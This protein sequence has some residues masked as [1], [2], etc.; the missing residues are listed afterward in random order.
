MTSFPPI[1]F[2]HFGKDHPLHFS[3]RLINRRLEDN[4]V[5]DPYQKAQF[6]QHQREETNIIER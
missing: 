5:Y 2:G 6:K 3:L 4:D 1:L